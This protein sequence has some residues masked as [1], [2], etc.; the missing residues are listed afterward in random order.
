[1]LMKA[2]VVPHPPIILPEVG[3]GEETKIQNT[4]DAMDKMAKEISELKPDTIIIT[5]PHAPMYRDAFYVSGGDI[6]RGNFRSFGAGEVEE[7]V[8]LDPELV[9]L[10]EDGSLP[11]YS[12]RAEDLDHGA[13]IP[14]R[15]IHKYYSDFKV[16][17]FGLSGLSAESHFKLGKKIKDAINSLGRRAVFIASGD[18]SHVLK[19]DGP[20]GFEEE[21]PEFDRLIIDALS[22]ADFS[23]LFSLPKRFTE[24]AAQC[25]LKSFQ[26]LSGALEDYNVEGK[27]YSYEG[28]FGVGYGVVGFTVAEK[29]IMDPYVNLARE[30]VFTYINT[31]R[32]ISPPNDLPKDMRENKAGT[33][34]TIYKNGEL[35]GC[36]GTISPTTNS[37]AEEII[38][39]AI[40]SSTRDPRFPEVVSSELENLKISV[41]VLKSPESIEDITQLDVKR[42]GVIVS[43]GY[44]RGLLLPNIDGIDDVETQVLIALKKAGIKH[45]ED[46]SMER[47]E[48]IRHE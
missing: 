13:I 45:T 38:Q 6:A 31:G 37:I 5:S 11:L 34:V 17:L 4:I 23:K 36:I 27:L 15:F 48:V 7:E 42:Y 16:V 2:Y 44:R 46:Y 25:G 20:Y 8:K 32:I 47:F 9:E 33:F 21:G 1:M 29:N 35:R 19:A 18:L 22:N 26:I 39:N 3:K 43:R 12:A 41:D 30:T 14:I 24:K 10:I 28:P 40:S